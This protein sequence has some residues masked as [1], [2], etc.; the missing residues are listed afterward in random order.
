MDGSVAALRNSAIDKNKFKIQ[1]LTQ[2][3]V[4]SKRYDC[5]LCFEVAEHIPTDKSEILVRN[6]TQAS[7]LIIFT[8]AHEGQG[9]HDHINE[10]PPQFWID[11]FTK[12]NF[13]FIEDDTQR[14][15][16]LL[17]ERG[18]LSWMAENILVFKK[19]V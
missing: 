1:D 6:I 19:L 9:G 5:A 3:F 11:I 15:K 12:N 14:L 16:S 13:R 7:D 17:S 8:S 10:Q 4:L 2:P 18:A